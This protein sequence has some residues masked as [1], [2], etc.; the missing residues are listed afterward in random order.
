M[1]RHSRLFSALILVFGV[2]MASFALAH[3]EGLKLPQPTVD[4]TPAKPGEQVAVFA[5]GCFWGI[6][7][8]FEHVKG[9]RTAST[10]YAGGEA[11]TANYDDV[12]E[13]DTGHAESV[14]VVYDPAQVSYATLLKVFFAVGL[15]PTEKDRQGPD[16]GTQYRSVVFATTPEQQKAA[17]AYI[18]QLN[19]AKVFDGPIVTEVAPLKAFYQAESYHQDYALL[20]PDNM[21]I[22]IN[23]APKVANL[24]KLFPDLYKPWQ[25]ATA[26]L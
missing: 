3:T 21:Y 24:K 5:G 1:K 8:V 25:R 16:S 7:A 18:A 23:D 19:A 6:E 17:S 11:K 4:A 12:S 20:H 15:D 10:G 26:S 2:A 14:R 13:G 22:V 9:V